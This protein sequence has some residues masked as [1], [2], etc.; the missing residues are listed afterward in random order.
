MRRID[1]IVHRHELSNPLSY[2]DTGLLIAL[3]KAVI[4]WWCSTDRADDTSVRVEQI[5]EQLMKE[6]K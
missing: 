5:A 2:D 3:A 4:E 6:Q 1:N